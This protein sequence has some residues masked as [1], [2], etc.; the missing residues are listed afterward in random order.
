MFLTPSG[1]VITEDLENIEFTDNQKSSLTKMFIE[2]C[3]E[4]KV[5]EQGELAHLLLESDNGTLVLANLGDKFLT[6]I[7]DGKEEI[8][9]AH[10]L[11]AITRVE[12][13]L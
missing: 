4:T 5:T 12:E 7:T 6:V 1:E 9:M 3:N 10:I 13:G 8:Q 2:Y 11:R